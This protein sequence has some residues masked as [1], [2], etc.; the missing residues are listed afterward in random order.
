MPSARTTRPSVGAPARVESPD[1]GGDEDY[2]GAEGGRSAATPAPTPG[3]GSGGAARRCEVHHAV[4]SV[5][6]GHRAVRRRPGPRRVAAAAHPGGRRGQPGAG[7]GGVR[8]RGHRGRPAHRAAE[9]Q[10]RDVRARGGVVH[11]GVGARGVPRRALDAAVGTPGGSRAGLRRRGRRRAGCRRGGGGRQRP[12]AHGGA[13]RVRLRDRHEPAG[14]LRGHRP[15]A[16]RAALRRGERRA[17]HDG[18]RRRRR[19]A[20][21]AAARRRGAGWP[22]TARRAGP[23]A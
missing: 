7:R 14:A 12:A 20:G 6:R 21:C 5:R 2:R 16:A 11:A 18:A 17:R 13:L 23:R 19:A 3:T 15:R 9:R 8:G 10:R 4:A 1:R 22:R